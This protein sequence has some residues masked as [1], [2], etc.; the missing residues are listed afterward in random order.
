MM[1]LWYSVAFCG[2][3]ETVNNYTCIQE[4][5]IQFLAPFLPLLYLAYSCVI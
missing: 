4:H 1:N 3:I 5:P 2:F